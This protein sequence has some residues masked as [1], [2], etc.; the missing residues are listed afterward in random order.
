LGKIV[1]G[2]F[3]VSLIT[4]LIAYIQIYSFLSKTQP[5][6]K[7]Q[8]DQNLN[9]LHTRLRVLD[10]AISNPVMA[11]GTSIL[12]TPGTYRD[13][14]SAISSSREVVSIASDY[15]KQKNQ[16]KIS[17]INLAT[18]LEAAM[19]HFNN[20]FASL[21]RL[22]L[23]GALTP[24]DSR[25][26]NV[27]AKSQELWLFSQSMTPLVPILPSLAGSEAPRRYL[28][29][30]QN[31]AEARGTGGILG[32][33]AI[34]TVDKGKIKFTNFESNS[35]LA[36]LEDIPIEMPAEF[37]RLYNDDPAYW[38]NSNLSPHFPYGAKIWLALWERQYGERL[39]GVMTFDPIA[40]S[41]LLRATGPIMVNGQ[42]ISSNNVVKVTLSD[43]YQEYE[44]DNVARK[45]FLVN[46]IRAVSKVIQEKKVSNESLLLNLLHPIN[47][48]RMLVFSDDLK[49]Q[50]QLEQ[51]S[52][53]G[54]IEEKQNN[55]YR[56]VVQNTSGNKM[57]YYLE[58]KLRIES[59]QCSPTKQTKVTFTLK[60][61]VTPEMKLPSYVSGRLDLNRPDGVANS[62]GTRVI[63]LAPQ[64]SRVLKAK[65]LQNGR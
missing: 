12:I 16:S 6:Y 14:S 22:Q 13:L 20:L 18:P 17:L 36:L 61:N 7:M 65:N 64:G 46:L 57:D 25:L 35:N 47:E 50:G 52:L 55:E 3:V 26:V 15:W 59:I 5:T 23:G 41:Y 28:M 29:A 10:I 45:T 34:I 39:D 58:R 33:F 48:H 43:V 54:S 44:R 63:I 8:V 60:N 32:A 24:L 37:T 19:P 42:E 56:L 4:T 49:E 1:L 53:S 31:S 9:E 2:L 38:P 21:S 11:V 27:R 30:F 62:Y 51:S 40:L